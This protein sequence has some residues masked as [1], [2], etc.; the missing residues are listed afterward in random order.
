[1]D[2]LI[3]SWMLAFGYAILIPLN[4]VVFGPL[5][6]K[7]PGRLKLIIW[8]SVIEAIFVG[9]L[10]LTSPAYTISILLLAGLLALTALIGFLASVFGWH[11]GKRT[12]KLFERIAG[13]WLKLLQFFLNT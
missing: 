10:Y 2:G 4:F 7:S 3:A 11:L 5:F 9:V 12:K 8:Y 6:R 1:M 13:F